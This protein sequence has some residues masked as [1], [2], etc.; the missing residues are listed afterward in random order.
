MDDPQARPTDR[1]RDA[2]TARINRAAGDGR[3]STADRDIRLGNVKSA[4]SRTE[5]DL[6]NR[7]LDLLEASLPT[8]TTTPATTPATAPATTPYGAFD[9][10]GGS[11]PFE[12]VSTV[13]TG[14]R[15]TWILTAVIVGVAVVLAGGLGVVGL[16]GA[17]VSGTESDSSTPALPPAQTD[18]AG[19][20]D[21]ADPSLGAGTTPEVPDSYALNVRGI[22]GFL[23]T[24]AKKFG[25][26]QVVDL[27]LYPDYAV[28]DVPVAGGKGRQAGWL[29]RKGSGWTSFGGVRAVF[30]GAATVDTRRLNV[31]ALVRNIAKARATL[32]V[33]TP[34][35]TYAI[36]R[37]VPRIDQVPSVDIHVA[38]GFNESGYLATR[39]DGTIERAYPFGQ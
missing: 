15:R 33:E 39:L 36:V 10:E 35:Q 13:V 6:M 19:P 37:Y 3:I 23:A 34:T 27:V 25:T 9:P 31:G 29:Y 32:K 22:T 16:I 30:P 18:D 12:G 4:Q 1:E 14:S 5:L 21:A 26:R 2:L 8:S 38:N 24:Y 7:D 11:S 20:T 17:R 28:V